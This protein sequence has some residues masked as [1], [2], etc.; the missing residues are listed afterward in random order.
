[1]RSLLRG[2]NNQI[3]FGYDFSSL[4]N[5]IQGHY[6]Y[7]YEGGPELAETLLA[8]K[9][10]D[11]HKLPHYTEYLTKDGWLTIDQISLDTEVAQYN[12]DTGVIEFVNPLGIIKS[13][14]VE[15]MYKFSQKSSLFQMEVSDKHRVLLLDRDNGNR[16]TLAKDVDLSQELYIPLAG[17]TISEGIEELTDDHLRLLIATQADG[18]LNTDCSAITFSFV[19]ERKVERLKTILDSL[20][21]SYKVSTHS[22]KNRD[23]I[24]IR[25]SASDL[26]V[27]VRSYLERKSLSPRL[28]ACSPNQIRVMVDE[29][30]YWDGTVPS[31]GSVTLDTTCKK[32]VDVLAAMVAMI[33]GR[34]LIREYDKNVRGSLMHIYRLIV[35]VRKPEI[36]VRKLSLEVNTY[37]V[38]CGCLQVPS[39]YLVVKQH[40]NIFITGNCY[41]EDTEILTTEGWKTFGDLTLEDKVL[42]YDPTNNV[43]SYVTPGEIVWQPYDGDMVHFE[44]EN[45][46]QLLT[47]NH[48]VLYVDH[49]VFKVGRADEL[50]DSEGLG[51]LGLSDLYTLPKGSLEPYSGYVGCVSV[52]S[53]FVTVRRNGKVF[54]SGNTINAKKL[55]I[56]RD[57][58]KALTYA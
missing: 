35:S 1:M 56:E 40:N 32:T 41:S 36:D 4:E 54:V 42:Q 3:Q 26:T 24:T 14:Q 11:L 43:S 29:I 58:A 47:P 13:D 9:P 12:P 23:E 52:P 16:T 30:K 33:G 37:K 34:A 10:N 44:D 46:D 51:Y 17:N 55:G 6:V 8:E 2:G 7:K 5:R 21:A 20:G 57:Q 22:R 25:I 31:H 27:L 49:D 48:R 53:G 18:Y 28:L 50:L 19:K 39:T 15:T 45:T 38:A